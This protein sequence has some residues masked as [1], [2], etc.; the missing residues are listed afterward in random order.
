MC[1]NY[2]YKKGIVMNDKQI[3]EDQI[4]DLKKTILLQEREIDSKTSTIVYLEKCL[5]I[6]KDYHG[7]IK[8]LCD[9]R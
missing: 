7:L 6:H 3:L 8:L 9:R 2:T 1:I 4:K 5:G